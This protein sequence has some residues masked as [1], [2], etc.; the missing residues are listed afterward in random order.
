VPSSPPGN[1][2]Q[3]LRDL[4]ASPDY[5]ARVS[6]V[7]LKLDAARSV[8]DV[9]DRLKE[10]IDRLGADVGA[11]ASY[12][13]GHREQ[14]FRFFLACDPQWYVEYEQSAWY[15]DDPWLEYASR[16][17]LPILSRD[18]PIENSAQGAIV[19]IAERHGFKSAI[20]VP[21]PAARDLTRLGMLCLGSQEPDYFK[22]DAFSSVTVA[23]LPLAMALLNWSTRDACREFLRATR[24][25][26]E[27][28]NLL[29]LVR[30]GLSTKAI[31][32]ALDTTPTSLN[33]RFQRIIAKLGVPNKMAAA[34]LAAGYGPI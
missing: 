29:E 13:V 5:F 12:I 9:A 2:L 15:A 19:A 7:T 20:V 4:V 30:R 3:S 23:A 25:H 14:S 26:P 34:K 10:G 27:D 28:L 22:G 11:F 32:R 6:E 21:A 8:A 16:H 33:S 24:L 18:I 31:A 17:A 1:R